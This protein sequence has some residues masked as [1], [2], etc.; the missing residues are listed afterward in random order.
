[1]YSTARPHSS[2]EDSEFSLVIGGTAKTCRGQRRRASGTGAKA[3]RTGFCACASGGG[4]GGG[5]MV[6]GPH[7]RDQ[8]DGAIWRNTGPH[9]HGLWANPRRQ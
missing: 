7:L 8:R 4:G 2:Q 1:M 6:V 9:R 3:T 5:G